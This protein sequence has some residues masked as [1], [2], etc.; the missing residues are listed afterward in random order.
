M[1]SVAAERD[2]WEQRWTHM[3]RNYRWIFEK[4]AV[5]DCRNQG[6]EQ[7]F[8]T[9]KNH[10]QRKSI[11]PT[12]LLFSP[13]LSYISMAS[14]CSIILATNLGNYILVTFKVVRT[15]NSTVTVYNPFSLK[16]LIF[17]FLITLMGWHLKKESQDSEIQLVSV[18]AKLFFVLIR[19]HIGSCTYAL[20]T[21]YL[22]FSSIF[23]SIC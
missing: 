14:R 21:L 22:K 12:A 19:V 16:C 8:K 4:G 5:L 7:E 20:G 13:W 23:L 9:A 3:I 6:L 10:K 11:V 1:G 15:L 17:F 2:K 18:N